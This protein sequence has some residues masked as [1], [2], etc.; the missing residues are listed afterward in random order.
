MSSIV[1]HIPG[2]PEA[3]HY[4]EYVT[5]HS[6]AA[7]ALAN[8]TFTE[9][10][11]S[12]DQPLNDA[13]P[14]G[15]ELGAVPIGSGGGAL[16]RFLAASIQAKSVIEVGTGAGVSGTW[17]L[18]GMA[19]DGVLTS[20]DREA[21]HQRVAK[22]TFMSA[23][24]ASNKFR[25]ISGP[26]LEVLPRLTDGA[27]DLVFIDAAKSE[28]AEYVTEAVRLLRPGGIL[29]VDN[30]LWHGQVADPTSRD[31]ETVAIRE[32]LRQVRDDERLT[33]V[34]LPSGDGLLAAVLRE[35]AEVTQPE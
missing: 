3:H 15:Q 2:S 21:E 22:Q 30:A 20:I 14:R 11:L 26:A 35:T 24:F 25:L 1:G 6:E 27:Y 8:R 4:A 5:E 23:G 10:W 33:S 17:L 7:V 19:E 31:P 12:E 34:L 13:R 29:A 9:T 32:L 16:L 18:R 28:Y